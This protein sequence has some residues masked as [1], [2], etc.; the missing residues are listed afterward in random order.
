MNDRAIETWQ[1]PEQ[2]T[3]EIFLT[4][5]SRLDVVGWKTRRAGKP[6]NVGFGIQ[7]PVFVQASELEASGFQ[8]VMINNPY[9]LGRSPLLL[10]EL[11]AT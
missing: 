10:H 8:I 4:F 1:H 11:G 7:V 3:G 9:G 2:Q 5:A 6:T